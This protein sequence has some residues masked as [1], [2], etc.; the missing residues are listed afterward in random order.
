MSREE[1]PDVFWHCLCF[2]F[3][4]L[5]HGTHRTY[6]GF[7]TVY[8]F[9]FGTYISNSESKLI[10]CFIQNKVGLQKLLSN[11]LIDLMLYIILYLLHFDVLSFYIYICL[12]SNPNGYNY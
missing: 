7:V 2:H 1:V 10:S 4:L 8:E 9:S 5:S 6:A 11:L 3:R 12:I